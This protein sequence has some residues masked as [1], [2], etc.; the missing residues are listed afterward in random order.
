M[1]IINSW[2][3]R[4]GNNIQQL[5]NAL[6]LATYYKHNIKI[7]KHKFFNIDLITEFFEKYEK[8]P[9]TIMDERNFFKNKHTDFHYSSMLDMAKN[10]IKKEEIKNILREAFKIKNIEKLDK[11]DL[12]IH[13]RSGDILGVNPHPNYVPPPLDYYVNEIKKYKYKKIIIVCEDTINPVVN[14]LLELYENSVHNINSLE[15]D[16]KIILGATNVIASFGSFVPNL[17]YLSNNN[18]KMSPMCYSLEEYK[19]YYKIMEPWKKTKEQ[20]DYILSYKNDSL[21]DIEP[22]N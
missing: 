3:G 7:P 12:I 17:L 21:P 5:I 11:E 19:D 9:L 20:V 18:K 6:S 13:I 14:K 10:N 4:L 16:I 15:E 1:I 22:D 2:N 8:N